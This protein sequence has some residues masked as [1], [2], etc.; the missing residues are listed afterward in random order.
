MPLRARKKWE[1]SI[2]KSAH[3]MLVQ[4][5][6]VDIYGRNIGY[7]YAEILAKIKEQ[8][9]DAKTSH[10]SLRKMVYELDSAVRV[11]ARKR[12]R[13]ASEG[14]AEVLLLRISR[15]SELGSQYGTISHSIRKKFPDQ[16]FFSARLKKL[17]RSLIRRGFKIPSR[18]PHP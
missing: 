10:D 1:K 17:E 15:N 13:Q 8:F 3:E 7:S 12:P 2:R 5:N 4:V 6:Y 9:P 14:Y 18:P 16:V 11:P